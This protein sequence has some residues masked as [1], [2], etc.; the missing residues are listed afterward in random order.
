MNLFNY[1]VIILTFFIAA[2]V[3]RS[4]KAGNKFAVGFGLVSLAVFV[5]ADILIIYYATQTI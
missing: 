4:I 5:F 1:I 2:G 3:V